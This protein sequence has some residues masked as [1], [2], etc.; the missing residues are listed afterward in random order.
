MQ[1]LVDGQVVLLLGLSNGAQLLPPSPDRPTVWRLTDGASSSGVD[2]VKAPALLPSTVP[3]SS[4]LAADC[5][6]VN[7]VVVYTP[8]SASRTTLTAVATANFQAA[9]QRK[10]ASLL[11]KGSLQAALK[12][13]G[14]I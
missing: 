8:L 4:T 1:A 2:G 5:S 13:K 9:K 11:K 3:D 12:L 7:G 10:A 6:V 14:I